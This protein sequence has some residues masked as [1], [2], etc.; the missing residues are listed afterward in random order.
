[1]ARNYYQ[2]VAVITCL[3]ILLCEIYSGYNIDELFFNNNLRSF[4]FFK[5]SHVRISE[6]KINE[7]YLFKPSK[8]INIELALSALNGI[9]FEKENEYRNKKEFSNNSHI[10]IKEWNKITKN[11][12][13]LNKNLGEKE[14][15]TKGIPE[16]Y[17]ISN[18]RDS[19]N[20]SIRFYFTPSDKAEYGME[21]IYKGT[22]IPQIY[23]NIF[24]ILVLSFMYLF[25]IKTVCQGYIKGK[26]VAKEYIPKISTLFT[27]FVIL[28]SLLVLF[29]AILSSFVCLILTFYFFSIS[30]NPCANI[31]FLENTKIKKEPI[32][33]VLIVYSE[34]LLIGNILYHFICSSKVLVYLVRHIK[35]DLLVHLI[36][37]LVLLLIASFIF[38]LMICNIFP[39]KKAQNFVFSFTS[40]YLII[41]CYTYF[42][43]LFALRF[44]NH[45]NIFQ[46]EPVMFFS[47]F[48]KFAF[49]KQNIFAL[50]VLLIMTFVSIIWPKLLKII[51][52]ALATK[53]KKKK[54][55]HRKKTTNKYDVI[56]NYFT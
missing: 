33:W 24:L 34:S 39:A 38:F 8:N 41:S 16:P 10:E 37:I 17:H 52:N 19:I 54:N 7:G 51:N 4:N 28:K 11:D 40:S 13:F 56:L 35:N 47:Y 3:I 45:T 20:N 49:N 1:M 46:I 21:I 44:L 18:I 2:N 23:D 42:Y 15:I 48:P 53:K 31:Y 6:L 26:H 30:M 5:D 50:F 22:Y 14:D 25:S 29:P 9:E 55:T 32:G 12:F 27:F 36:C 43:N